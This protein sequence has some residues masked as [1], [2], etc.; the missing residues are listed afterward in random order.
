MR[1]VLFG[2]LTR[3]PNPAGAIASV[4]SA[5]CSS[6]PSVAIEIH[7]RTCAPPYP[8]NV[9]KLKLLTYDWPSSRKSG[10]PLE[11]PEALIDWRC[12]ILL[13]AEMST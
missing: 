8:S 4:R 3:R 10:V 5:A 11:N 6:T 7:E 12:N 13:T 9:A 2:E 1:R